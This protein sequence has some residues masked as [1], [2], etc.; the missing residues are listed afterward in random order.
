M[1]VILIVQLVEEI[2]EFV[3]KIVEEFNF[4]VVIFIG[5]DVLEI[6]D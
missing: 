3:L 2:V 1:I 5:I 6:F 4:V